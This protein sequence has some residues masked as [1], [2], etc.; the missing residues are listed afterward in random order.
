MQ[1]EYKI[2]FYIYTSVIVIDGYEKYDNMDC[3][4][5]NNWYRTLAAAKYA[6]SSNRKCMGICYRDLS[7]FTCLSLIT[8]VQ[9]WSKHE[10]HTYNSKI[11]DF[12]K[13]V[14]NFGPA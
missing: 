10:N 8:R 4:D 6:C 3:I 1:D 13:N 7:F 14:G 9:M 2:L 12:S 11:S 5:N